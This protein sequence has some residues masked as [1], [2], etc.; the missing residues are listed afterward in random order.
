[1][2]AL[3]VIFPANA[4]GGYRLTIVTTRHPAGS[5][6]LS[7]CLDPANIAAN[8][9]FWDCLYQAVEVLGS[10]D[11]FGLILADAACGSGP[12]VQE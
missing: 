5:A 11:R 8:G 1:M 6:T 3:K 12:D 2:A 9:R 7:V 4:D 10:F